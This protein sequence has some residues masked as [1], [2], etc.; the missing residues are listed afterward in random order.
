M[1]AF[2]LLAIAYIATGIALTGYDFSAPPIHRKGYVSGR[3]YG[4][5]VITWFLWPATAFMDSYY[6]AKEGKAGGRFALGVVVL[7]VAILFAASPILHFLGSS[8]VLAY[9]GCFVLV[10]VF[11]PMLAAIALPRHDRL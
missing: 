2:A 6:A 8:S 4:V 1:E 10:V 3:K 7:F 5:A 11:S 9:L